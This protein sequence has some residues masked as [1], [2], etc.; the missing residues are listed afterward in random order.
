M[1]H[2]MDERVLQFLLRE[3][4]AFAKTQR[5]VREVFLAKQPYPFPAG[6]HP[7]VRVRVR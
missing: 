2:L 6:Q 4:K 3:V 5:E 7:H 1:D